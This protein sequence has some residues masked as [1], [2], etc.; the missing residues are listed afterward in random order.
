[1]TDDPKNPTITRVWPAVPEAEQLPARD[2]Y[3]ALDFNALAG[4]DRP[5]LIVNMVATADGQGKIGEN[6]AELGDAADTALFATLRER[7]DC[8]MAGTSTIGIEN[9]SAPA[10]QVETQQRRSAAGLRP[11]PFIATVTRSGRLPLSA[12]LFS[13]P[14]LEVLVFSDVEPDTGSAVA[15]VQHIATTDPVEVAEVLRQDF[16]VRAALLEG[17]PKLNAPFFSAGVV[18]ELF[19]TVAPLLTGSEPSFPIISGTLPDAVPLEIITCW[20]GAEHLF[21]R[22]RVA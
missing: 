2:A 22:Y 1:M 3:A 11:R 8:V 5:H 7:V 14:E 15:R 18:D 21:L 10:R 16:D 13:D 20:A 17:G 9:Y 4:E 6:T 12:P 19:L